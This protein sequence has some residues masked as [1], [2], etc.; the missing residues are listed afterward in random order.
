[1]T[2][3][4]LAGIRV[5]ELAGIGPAPFAGM[6][7]ADMGA[8]VIRLDRPAPEPAGANL[9][10]AQDVLGR[11]RRSIAVNL[12]DVRGLDVALRLVDRADVLVEGFRPGV[13]ERLGIGPDACADRN[14]RLIYARMTGWGQEGPLAQR[15]GHDIDYIAVAG[16]LHP[17]GPADGPPAVPL[18]LVADFGGGGMF[19]AVGILAALLERERSGVGQVVDAAMVDGVA[20]LTA[21]FQGM[22][23]MGL[24]S[25]SREANLLDGGAP[26]YRTYRC[27]DGEFI[28]V[29]ALE[30]RFYAQ[31]LDRLGLDPAAWPQLDPMRWPEQRQQLADLFASR[32]RDEW[33]ELF[34]G[35]D[36]CVAPVLALDEAPE[37]PHLVARGTF[38]VHGGLRQ[39]SPAPRFSRTSSVLGR[40]PVLP[41]EHTA[42][43]L[44]DVGLDDAAVAAL[45]KAGVVRQ[46]SA[47]RHH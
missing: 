14:P 12:K 5:V 10:P 17:V 41:G 13:A 24:W 7:L 23:A 4:P 37:H 15:A 38:S 9:P 20:V 28:A 8:D 6:L 11:G 45:A 42:E 36:A 40:P 22:L 35:S 26:F 3:G 25:R 31:L 33:A 29:G 19:C 21:M 46:G 30:S 44:R 47:A 43:I 18:N 16:A 34:E 2:S 39:P 1:V 27:A 32:S